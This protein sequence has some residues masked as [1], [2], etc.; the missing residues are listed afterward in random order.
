MH[1]R[2]TDLRSQVPGRGYGVALCVEPVGGRAAG[3]VGP[4]GVVEL[5]LLAAT[6]VQGHVVEVRQASG[7]DNGLVLLARIVE[8][9]GSDLN[10]YSDRHANE[11]AAVCRSRP[12]GCSVLSIYIS[13]QEW[14]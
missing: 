6:L 12:R 10:V 5:G 9:Y 11:T 1:D 14:S 13:A 7:L 3:S 8:I 2:D 4:L